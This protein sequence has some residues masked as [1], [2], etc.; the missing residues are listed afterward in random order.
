MVSMRRLVV[1]V[2]VVVA[3]TAATPARGADASE[4][5]AGV[6]DDGVFV[7]PGAS[8]TDAEVGDAVAA[9]RRT[10]EDL[11]IVVL[12]DEPLAGATTFADAVFDRTG[13]GL[14][15]VVAPE[16]VG[17]AG[18]GAVY[19]TPAIE[20][21]LDAALAA[22]DDDA[23][24]VA[25]FVAD[26][27]GE[28]VTGAPATTAA[29]AGDGSSGGIG[30]GWLWIVLLVVIV[31]VALIWLNRRSQRRAREADE[32]RIAA[33]KAEIQ[34]QVDAVANDILDLE[35]E[36]RL[37]DDARAGRFYE[38][39]SETYRRALEALGPATTP[40]EL[41]EISNDLDEAIW[42]LDSAEAVLD[43]KALPDKPE[44]RRLEP[45]VREPVGAPSGAGEYR[46]RPS[47]R[48]TL[49][50]PR[51]M[52][53]LIMIGGA[54]MT[55]RG[56]RSSRGGGGLFG[57]MGPPMRREASRRR[58]RRTVVPGPSSPPSTR[59]A[60]PPKPDAHR[61]TGGRRVRGGRRRRR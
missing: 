54:M 19:D 41:L 12:A 39:A 34:K 58:S 6:R 9:A 22:G 7:E 60:P 36:V 25:A 45:V 1:V 30:L 4:A 14:V 28:L 40:H 24:L 44:R 49:S 2:A 17:Y 33:A 23:A 43:G 46:R 53:M 20:A 26:L 55:G 8:A 38:E 59:R 37:A 3:V 27:T 42:R 13:A 21:A 61:G 52:D 50:G 48:S 57:G 35:D 56:R 18:I 31:G 5:A 47:R 11:S 32:A 29:T 10:G 51:M 16:S 15:V